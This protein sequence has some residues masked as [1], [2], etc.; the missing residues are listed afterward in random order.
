MSVCIGSYIRKLREGEA[1]A[2]NLKESGRE[3]HGV[4]DSLSACKQ[5]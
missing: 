4:Y 5:A 2:E 3:I 1:N